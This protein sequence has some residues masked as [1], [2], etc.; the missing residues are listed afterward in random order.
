MVG[1]ADGLS[2]LPLSTSDVPDSTPAD[3][4]ML[5]SAYPDALSPAAVARMTRRDSL[6]SQVVHAV[7]TGTPLPVGGDYIPFAAR[8]NKLSL[9]EGCL[10][11]GSRV[12]VPKLL[13]TQVLQLLH[14]GHPG[15]EKTK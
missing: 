2:R 15:V 14:A 11:W 3:V 10:L 7:L 6:L 1:H 5:E 12:V 8:Y 4:F 9:H 13:Q